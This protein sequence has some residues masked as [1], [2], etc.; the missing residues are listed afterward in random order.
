MT[1]QLWPMHGFAE[2]GVAGP[3]RAL[4]VDAAE[5]LRSEIEEHVLS[6]PPPLGHNSNQSRHLDSPIVMSACTTPQILTHIASAL[7]RDIVLWRSNFFTKPPGSPEL[8]WHRDSDHWGDILR[9]RR[10]VSAWLALDRATV[11]NGC[12][13]VIPRLPGLSAEP[14]ADPKFVLCDDGLL[15]TA[16]DV[17][18]EPGEYMLFDESLVHGS[19]SNTTEQARLGLAIRFTT[20]DVEV[21]SDSIFPG[22]RCILLHVDSTDDFSPA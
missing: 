20:P 7:G 8:G 12:L 5:R 4:S 17:Q 15:A 13:R 6:T 2:R 22:H 21:D 3:F 16:I 11:E 18:L 10:N 1:G 9:P 19:Y 14:S